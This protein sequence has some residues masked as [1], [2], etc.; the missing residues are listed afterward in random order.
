MFTYATAIARVLGQIEPIWDPGATSA[1]QLQAVNQALEYLW[2]FGDWDGLTTDVKGMATTGGILSLPPQYRFLT[3]LKNSDSHLSVSIK[4]Q[5]FKYSPSSRQVEDFYGMTGYSTWR[6]CLVAYDLGDTNAGISQIIQDAV[7]GQLLALVVQNG[8]LGLVAAPAGSIPS[9]ILLVDSTTNLAYN[10]IAL[11]TVFELQP[12]G[13]PPAG[14]VSASCVVTDSVTSQPYAVVVSGGALGIVPSPSAPASTI[15]QYRIAGC[16]STVDTLTFEGQAKLRY[17]YATN[18]N[19]IVAPD[20]FQALLSAVR[21]FHFLDVGDESRADKHFSKALE[22]L[23]DDSKDILGEEDMGCLSLD[24]VT[25]GGG[26][27]NIC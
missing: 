27:L 10:L 3:A 5:G 2:N 12:L 15:R 19:S 4:S 22:L 11:N 7:T 17:T 14:L 8:V 16:P 24:P 18:P 13:I 9:L 20:N 1:Q 25:S 21:G 23:N 6:G 26:L